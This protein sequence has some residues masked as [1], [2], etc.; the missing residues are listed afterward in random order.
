MQN[1]NVVHNTSV[2]TGWWGAEPAGDA[3]EITDWPLANGKGATVIDNTIGFNDFRGSTI[4][5][6]FYPEAAE[7]NNTISRNL[8]ENR[9]HGLTP[10][11]V[12]GPVE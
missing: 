11:N 12:F 1:N 3:F 2:V 7:D 8:G 9:G 10:A 4:E 6:Y 5:M